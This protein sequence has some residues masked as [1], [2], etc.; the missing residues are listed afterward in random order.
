MSTGEQEGIKVRRNQEKH[1]SLG[2][3]EEKTPGA[4]SVPPCRTPQNVRN[5]VPT[6]I[7]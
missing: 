4:V 5:I 2:G 3:D 1:G 7:G 6:L